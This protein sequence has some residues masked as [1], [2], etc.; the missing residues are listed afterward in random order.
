MTVLSAKQ[1]LL[2]GAA[3]L[4]V[5]VFYYGIGLIKSQTLASV[6]P[7]VGQPAPSFSAMAS[8][9]S[10]VTLADYKG[11]SLILVFYPMDNTPGCT[12]QLCALRDQWPRLQALNTDV[13]GVNPASLA[14]HKG[15][16]TK[17]QLPFPLLVDEGRRIAEAYG[18]GE[19]LGANN[20]AVVIVGPNGKL[21]YRKEG[22]PP[23]SEFITAIEAQ[24]KP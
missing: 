7:K 12:I 10:R 21:I 9:G 15:F 22:L 11:R 19:T 8:S 24:T 1:G 17:Q 16:A 2:L 13:L 14:S 18:I 4:L 3:L 20:R 6:G 23:V 5:V